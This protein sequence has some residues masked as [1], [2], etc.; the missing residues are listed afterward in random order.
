MLPERKPSQQVAAFAAA[1]SREREN[2]FP[3]GV[4]EGAGGWYSDES[5][6]LYWAAMRSSLTLCEGSA[7]SSAA[8]RA[9]STGRI[10]ACVRM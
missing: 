5:S 10:S 2:Q 9:S 6:S 7:R 4:L 3:G 8:A 1:V